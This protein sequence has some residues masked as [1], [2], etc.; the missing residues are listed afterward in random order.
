MGGRGVHVAW[1]RLEGTVGGING[2]T[3][4]EGGIGRD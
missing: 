3:R 4:V 1:G 2:K